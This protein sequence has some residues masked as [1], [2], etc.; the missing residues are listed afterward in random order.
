VTTRT[1]PSCHT[2]KRSLAM[3]ESAW[4]SDWTVVTPDGPR[5]ETRYTCDDCEAKA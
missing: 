4:A 2:C 1:P 5:M 3:D